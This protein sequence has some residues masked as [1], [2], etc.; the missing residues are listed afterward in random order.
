[1]KYYVTFGSDKEFPFTINEYIEIVA[2]S[3]NE[4]RDVFAKVYPNR[5]GSSALNFAFM[6]S[7]EEWKS[8]KDEYY[9]D[10]EPSRILVGVTKVEKKLDNDSNLYWLTQELLNCGSLDIEMLENF[11]SDA[12]MDAVSRLRDEGF[13][14]KDLTWNSLVGEVA[15]YAVCV[16]LKEAIESKIENDYADTPEI[17]AQLRELNPEEDFEICC[18]CI[19]SSVD[20]LKNDDIYEKYL[21]EEMENLNNILGGILRY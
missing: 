16:T 12:L 6:Y 5:P 11:D 21:H 14:M 20:V 8:I 3:M 15:E 7:E 4:A 13:S 1:M 10:V 19:A 17:T 9:K 2:E 18:N